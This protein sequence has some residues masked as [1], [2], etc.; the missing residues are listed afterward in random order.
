MSERGASRENHIIWEQRYERGEAVLRYPFDVVVSFVF[1][2]LM[3]P[4]KGIPV[5][6]LDFGCGAGNHMRFLVENG[7]QAFGVDVAPSAL[8]LS[9][10]AVAEIASDY[11]RERFAQ[12]DGNRIPYEDASFDAVLDR[13]SLGQN[14]AADLGELV[15]EIHRVLKPGGVYFGINFSDTHPDLRY[16]KSMGNGDFASFSQGIFKGIGTRHFFSVSEVQK[17]FSHFEIDDIR[18]LKDVSVLGRGG[19]VQIITEARRPG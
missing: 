6:I 8:R 10:E 9:G 2:K 3:R 19:N 15:T 5:S 18:L 14:T 13:S 1:Q 17:L 4:T 7:Y 12:M 16:G 11:P